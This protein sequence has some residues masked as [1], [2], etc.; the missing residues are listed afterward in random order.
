[1]E[2]Y[3][4]TALQAVERASEIC[5]K[6]QAQLVAEDSLT[7]KDRSPVTVADFASQAVICRMLNKAFPQIPIVGEEDASSLRQAENSE[8]LQK[9]NQFVTDR[10]AE[11]ILDDIDLGNGEPNP[12]LFWTLDPI[13]GTKGFLRKDQYAVALALI[14]EGEPVLGVLGCPKLP[15]EEG[16]NGG[17]LFFA[18]K[19]QGAFLRPLGES[20]TRQVHVSENS[21]EDVVRFLE[22]VEAAH[23]NH[24]LQGKLMETFGERAQSVR[25]DSQVKYAVLSRGGAEVYLRLPNPA[26]PDYREKIWDHAAGAIIVQEAGG[27]VTDMFG[28]PLQFNQGKLLTQNRGLVVT[29]GKLHDKIIALLSRLQND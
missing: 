23:S 28:K 25:Y 6:V 21:P 29:N 22:S 26:K 13:D 19:G 20:E 1:M 27:T 7:K 9:I 12:Q 2:K 14:K 18:I 24:S 16:K 17:T 11:E 3:L 5:A 8:I 10:S 4:E 15:A